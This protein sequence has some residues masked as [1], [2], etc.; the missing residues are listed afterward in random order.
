MFIKFTSFELIDS[1]HIMDT[2]T[3]ATATTINLINKAT[4]LSDLA[5]SNVV[6]QASFTA[7]DV[8]TDW[9]FF[10][11]VIAAIAFVFWQ[12]Q[13]HGLE[14]FYHSCFRRKFKN[15]GSG[16][17]EIAQSRLGPPRVGWYD[18]YWTFIHTCLTIAIIYYVYNF[19]F[20]ITTDETNKLI[21]IESLFII[22]V[23]LEKLWRKLFWNYHFSRFAQVTSCICFS[24]VC[25][26][27]I[28][29][30]VMFGVVG[31]W[32][33]F[34]L[35]FPVVPWYLLVMGWN[36]YICY[37]YWSKTAHC[38]CHFPGDSHRHKRSTS[39]TP[40]TSV[41]VKNGD[42]MNLSG[43]VTTQRKRGGNKK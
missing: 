36:C 37:C 20:P 38:K 8:I 35:M 18:F 16:K 15:D 12:P 22:M 17:K 3:T 32:V 42:D 28:T 14:E 29:L 43:N 41:A 26:I 10:V 4:S 9:Q 33:S 11:L 40:M 1:R 25:C 24:L 27:S 6:T 31:S 21:S 5:T 19:K 39:T 23:L 34:G 30:L 2:T 13:I 7:Q